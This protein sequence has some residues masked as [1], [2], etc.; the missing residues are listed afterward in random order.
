M[1]KN[2]RDGKEQ[3][4]KASKL[5]I[6]KQCDVLQIHRSSVYDIP[7]GERSLNLKMMRWID[8]E[9]LVHPWLGVPGMTTWLNEASRLLSHHSHSS[10]VGTFATAFKACLILILFLHNS[11]Y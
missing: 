7:K 8:Q 3:V 9:H 6:A 5:S 11:Y 2:S 4:D 1:N 10:Q